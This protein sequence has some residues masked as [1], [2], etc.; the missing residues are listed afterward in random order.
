[1]KHHVLKCDPE[2]FVQLK[3]G[4]KTFEIR[5]N[6]RGYKL[7]DTLEIQPYDRARQCFIDHDPLHFLVTHILYGPAYDALPEG[8]CIMSIK[9]YEHD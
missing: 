1:M 3:I 4:A 9:P 7:G 8:W 6:D 2:H 5:Q